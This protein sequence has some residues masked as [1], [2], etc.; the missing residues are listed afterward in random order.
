MTGGSPVPVPV[1]KKFYVIDFAQELPELV[2]KTIYFKDFSFDLAAAVTDA[3]GTTY[4]VF[5]DTDLIIY[6]TNTEFYNITEDGFLYG[7]TYYQSIT[8]GESS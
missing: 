5:N 1:A 7:G 8:L 4:P 6:V 2:G 3:R